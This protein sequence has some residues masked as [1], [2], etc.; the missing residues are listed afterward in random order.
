LAVRDLGPM[1]VGELWAGSPAD[2]R[3][4]KR[5][6]ARDENDLC[7]VHMLS[8]GRGVVEQAGQRATLGPGDLVF[9]DLARP[10]RWTMS[11][12]RSVAVVFPRALLPLDPRAADGLAGVRLAGDRGPG[13]V[14]SSLVRE[15][16]RHAG[17]VDGDGGGRL[18][19]A[20]LDV[21]AAALA[22]RA[23]DGAPGRT[24]EVTVP[25][26]A[27]G[28]ARLTAVLADIE[29]NLGDPGLTPTTLA[30]AHHMSLRALHAL[31]DEHVATVAS[32]IRHRRLER[33]RHDL[34]DPAQRDVAVSAIA[35]R[36]GLVNPTHFS[37]TFRAAYE[38]SPVEYRRTALGHGRPAMLPDDTRRQEHAGADAPEI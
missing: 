32:W 28:R 22:G 14:A 16:A 37:R 5:H 24:R 12:M 8:A 23:A 19:T 31:F 26:A 33:T 36:W 30:A 18:G 20:V 29:A 7:K 4:T 27:A 15:L 35:A 6:V 3:R 38:V 34:A 21:L 11:A 10:V 13:A 2:V 17:A 9:V 25:A 1:V